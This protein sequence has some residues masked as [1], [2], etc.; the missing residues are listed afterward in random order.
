MLNLYRVRESTQFRGAM[1]AD[2]DFDLTPIQ[3]ETLKALRTPRSEQ[4]SVNRFALQ[5]LVGFALAQISEGRPM[6]T[7][8]GRDVV[9]R[10]SPRLW[11]VAA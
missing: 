10:G 11:D 2:I 9:L 5:E 7:P 8:K 1:N 6:I 3:W 4:L